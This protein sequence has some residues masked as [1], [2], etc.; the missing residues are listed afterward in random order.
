M[1]ILLKN[2]FTRSPKFELSLFIIILAIHHPYVKS[3]INYLFSKKIKKKK[4]EYKTN[5]KIGLSFGPTGGLFMYSHGIAKYLEENYDLSNVI[6]AG[7]SGG[8]QPSY[9]LASGIPMDT[10]YKNWLLPM[11]KDMWDDNY[12][13][14]FT[15]LFKPWC[16]SL[17]TGMNRSKRHLGKIQIK[18]NPIYK[19]NKLYL[20]ILDLYN[21]KQISVSDWRSFDDLFNGVQ[22]TQFIPFIFGYPFSIFR[23]R[24]CID[25]FFV[26]TY[27]EP[28]EDVYWIHLNPYKWQNRGLIHGILA[29]NNFYDI[30]FHLK[31]R[32]K[33]YNDA[34]K[35]KE[36]FKL[37]PIK[38]I[39]K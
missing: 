1:R 19:G 31:E 5:Q 10:A 24:W 33:G 16:F 37:L 12:T 35:N 30:N 32:D 8:C 7:T 4:K 36:L 15:K 23:N 11:M 3:M 2:F 9:F 18:N 38:K 27:F 13:N 6:F 28:L 25:G 21:L 39:E 14:I 26:D 29:L 20:N 34:K 22:S 17:C